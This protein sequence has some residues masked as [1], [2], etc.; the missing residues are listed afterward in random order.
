MTSEW[1]FELAKVCTAFVAIVGAFAL[2][3][4]FRLVRWVGERVRAGVSAAFIQPASEAF[5]EKAR[6]A[7]ADL[8]DQVRHLVERFDKHEEYVRYHLGPNHD[9]PPVYRRLMALERA[10]NIEEGAQA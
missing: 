3:R 9:S 1:M 6:E 10:H 2:I 4:R 5:E 7:N 8:A